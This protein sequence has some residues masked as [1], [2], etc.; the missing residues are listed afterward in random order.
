MADFTLSDFQ[1]CASTSP[2]PRP[3]PTRWRVAARPRVAG[4]LT[5]A[6]G[7]RTLLN[8][9][10]RAAGRVHPCPRALFRLPRADLGDA[11]RVRHL[12]L[13]AGRA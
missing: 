7:A 6:R 5:T 13:A 8:Q 9:M 11:L 1:T 2:S 10:L 12:E 4:R 3:P